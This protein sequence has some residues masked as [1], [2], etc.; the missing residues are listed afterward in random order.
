MQLSPYQQINSASCSPSSQTG[1]FQAGRFTM[2]VITKATGVRREV[3]DSFI[4]FRSMACK[5]WIVGGTYGVVVA[6]G[7]VGGGGSPG[8]SHQT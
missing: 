1:T 7:K 4:L 5:Q 8:I 6:K 2:G 3:V